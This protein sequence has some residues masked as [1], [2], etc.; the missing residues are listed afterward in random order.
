MGLKL[1]AIPT[2]K[3]INVLSRFRP[4]K[5]NIPRNENYEKAAEIYLHLAHKH[6]GIAKIPRA[7]LFRNIRSIMTNE[8]VGFLIKN[9][10]YEKSSRTFST[11]GKLMKS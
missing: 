10:V 3:L 11:N 4:F 8:V 9:S 7:N 1:M 6:F 5:L 2:T